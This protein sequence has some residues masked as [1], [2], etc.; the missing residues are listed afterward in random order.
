MKSAFPLLSEKN[1]PK[2]QDEQ[3]TVSQ[4]RKLGEDSTVRELID[5]RL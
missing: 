5:D 2:A 4:G 1:H 3:K